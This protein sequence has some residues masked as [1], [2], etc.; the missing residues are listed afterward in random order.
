MKKIAKDKIIPIA[1]EGFPFILPVFGAAI[2]F[3]FID[4]QLIGYLALLLAFFFLYFF[5]DPNRSV[6]DN[7]N[8]ILSPADGKIVDLREEYNEKI[9]QVTT[10]SIFLSIFDVHVNRF[11]VTGELI[12]REYRPGQFLPAF[13]AEASELN[14]QNCLTIKSRESTLIVKQVG[15]IIARRIVCWAEKGDF[16]S[17]GERFGLIRFGSRVD[18]SLPHN[19]LIRTKIGKRVKSGQSIIASFRE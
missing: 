13:K 5:R 11:P 9:G 4:R 15:G 17:A 18:I 16:L 8:L 12:E 2:F 14:E 10:I 1:T 6:P 7:E 19:V 3:F